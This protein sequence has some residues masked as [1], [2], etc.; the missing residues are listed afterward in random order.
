V[1]V[2]RPK[3]GP[4]VLIPMVDEFVKDIDLLNARILV[5]LIPGM[6]NEEG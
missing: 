1:L 4:D 5:H 6:L 2:I 3:R